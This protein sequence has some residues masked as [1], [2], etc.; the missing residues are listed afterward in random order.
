MCLQAI[1]GKADILEIESSPYSTDS[2]REI[3]LCRGENMLLLVKKKKKKRLKKALRKK[4]STDQ[5]KAC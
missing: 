2:E 3:S 5:N 4:K 1:S